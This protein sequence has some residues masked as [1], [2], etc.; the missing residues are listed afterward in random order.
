MGRGVYDESIGKQAA[1]RQ[2]AGSLLQ[3][4]TLPILVLLLTLGATTGAQAV[5][6]IPF[7]ADVSAD[8]Y[9]YGFKNPSAY[10]I[11]SHADFDQFYR[12]SSS[13]LDDPSLALLNVDRVSIVRC[14]R[15]SDG[16]N[17]NHQVFDVTWD[18]T[19]NADILFT[20]PSL[21]YDVDLIL[22]DS[23]FDPIFDGNEV[24]VD[25]DSGSLD[26]S[27]LELRTAR[28]ARLDLVND[29]YFIDFNL[30]SMMNGETK[31]IGF[32]YQVNNPL[33]DTNGNQVG[34]LFPLI[35]PGAFTVFTV[36]PEPGTATLLGL[37]LAALA[38]RRNRA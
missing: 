18:V 26:G 5:T 10:G 33:P 38:V 9:S 34:V 36:V 13:P 12:A 24:S 30:G 4:L 21:A 31:R 25:Y 29:Y 1:R 3:G 20:D 22:V 8:G 37:G 32:T 16:C 6:Y 19:F 35:A 11:T 27:F 2:F 15:A 17:S 14:A 28:L 7:D 23:D